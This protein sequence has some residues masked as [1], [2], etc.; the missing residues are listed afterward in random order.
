[1]NQHS[2]ENSF[3]YVFPFE[4]IIIAFPIQKKRT[5]DFRHPFSEYKIFNYLE[6]SEESIPL[7]RLFNCSLKGYRE[8]EHPQAS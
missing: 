8:G 6:S 3:G 2:S 5:P 7:N 4:I 1:M